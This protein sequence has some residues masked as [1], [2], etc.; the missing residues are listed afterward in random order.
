MAQ[1]PSC[2]AG[3]LSVSYGGPALDRL[4][5]S[6][7]DFILSCIVLSCWLNTTV[8]RCIMVGQLTIEVLGE[9]NVRQQGQ[10]LPLPQSKKTRALLGYLAVI[11]KPQR[12][13][14]LCKMFWEVPD[15]PRASLRWSLHKLRPIVNTEGDERLRADHNSV[16]LSPQT[17][18]VD[19]NGIASLRPADLDVL[20]TDALESLAAT[21]RGEFLEGLYLPHCPN[22]EAWRLYHRD[23]ALRV[24]TAIL[25]ALLRRLRDCPDRVHAHSHGSQQTYRR[26]SPTSISPSSG[27]SLQ[28]SGASWPRVVAM[29]QTSHFGFHGQDQ[30][31]SPGHSKRISHCHL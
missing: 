21:F 3:I 9:L 23:M 25:R 28:S 20:D 14:H 24:H 12:R 16:L 26:D 8:C 17:I 15:D 13:E 18:D 5:A 31:S 2:R 6:R 4:T 1:T 30:V 10:L 22:F 19:F 29:P 7:A 27:W 11:G